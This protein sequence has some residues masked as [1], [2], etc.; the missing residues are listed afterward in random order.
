M[1][2]LPP[3]WHPP[4]ALRCRTTIGDGES[5]PRRVLGRL[6]FGLVWSLVMLRYALAVATRRLVRNRYLPGGIP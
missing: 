6:P 4:R 2:S 5:T 3:A 1:A